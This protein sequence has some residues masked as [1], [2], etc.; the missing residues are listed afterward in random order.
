MSD[1]IFLGVA[2]SQLSGLGATEVTPVMVTHG[3]RAVRFIGSWL[4]TYTDSTVPHRTARLSDPSTSGIRL[5]ADS[6][7]SD[8]AVVDAAGTRSLTEMAP[9]YDYILDRFRQMLVE[10]AEHA[11]P[12]VLGRAWTNANSL[13]SANTPTPSVVPSEANGIAFV[14]HK[15]G[16]DVEIDTTPAD[17]TVWAHRR[18]D[19]TEWYGPLTDTRDR[20]LALLRDLA[21]G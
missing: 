4:Q 9:W 14:W 1:A 11:G 6:L 10:D 12:S 20:L 16:W 7:S 3:T 18:A 17:T 8:P 15:R 19:R 21:N 5:E 13:F 2:R